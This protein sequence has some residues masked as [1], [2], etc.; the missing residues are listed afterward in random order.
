MDK[1]GLLHLPAM[2]ASA[3]LSRSSSTSSTSSNQTEAVEAHV[4]VEADGGLESAAS[5]PKRGSLK[6]HLRKAFF[7]IPL[8]ATPLQNSDDNEPDSSDANVRQPRHHHHLLGVN[9]RNAASDTDTSAIDS[10]AAAYASSALA[11][12]APAASSS[13]A[14]DGI[15]S[16]SGSELFPG[17]FTRRRRQKKDRK[18]RYDVWLEEND[19]K[20]WERVRI[21]LFWLTIG[22]MFL[23]VAVAGVMIYYMPRSC[24]PARTWYQGYVTVNIR[25]DRQQRMDLQALEAR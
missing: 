13:S 1:P 24:D 3:R 23:C 6:K 25:P 5:P 14:L 2:S 20:T 22:A 17:D 9:Y 19:S 11:P 8:E 15:Q 10:D 16:D 4:T 21:A 7:A 18:N 12:L